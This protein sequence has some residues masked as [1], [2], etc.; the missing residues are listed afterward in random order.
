[1]MNLPV[2]NR[3]DDD[4]FAH[5]RMSF[6]DHIEELRTRMIRAIMGFLVAMV[7]GLFIG[8][9]VLDFIQAPVQKQLENA[10]DARMARLQKQFDDEQK[11]RPSDQ[12]LDPNTTRQLLAQI[13]DAGVDG[14]PWRTVI[15]KIDANQVALTANSA[16]RQIVRPASLTVLTITE[17]FMTYLMVSIYCGIVLS[18]PWIFWQLWQFIA[19]GLY[20]HEKRYV[21]WYLPLSIVLFLGGCAL[22]EFVVLPI[23]ISYL[24]SFSEWLGVENELR[25]SEWLSFAIMVPVVFGVAFQTPLVMLFLERVGIVQVDFYTKNR[26]MAIF[27]LAIVA[28]LLAVAPD[29]FSMM[30]LALPMWGLYEF[31]ILLCRFSPRAKPLMEE[32]DPEEMVEV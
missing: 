16:S 11:A 17:S 3:D 15:I 18:S 2:F 30:S 14:A 1:M 5:T 21:H 6:G 20:P 28:A 24:L 27:V 9:P 10:Y 32:P 22:A 25:L 12:P 31:G 13:Q 29:A 7:I 23:G 4:L 8:K 19:A 26:K